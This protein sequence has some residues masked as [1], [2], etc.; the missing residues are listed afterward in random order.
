ML[1]AIGEPCG[2]EEEG[3]EEEGDARRK[4]MR[5]MKKAKQDEDE[6]E[7]DGDDDEE[8]DDEEGDDEAGDEE[9]GDE[10][11]G[12]EA[13]GD[14][15]SSSSDEVCEKIIEQPII[16]M[17]IP[18]PFCNENWNY[19]KSGS[20]WN[21]KCSESLSQSPIN[22]KTTEGCSVV[23]EKRVDFTFFDLNTCDLAFFY[24]DNMLKLKCGLDSEE[25]CEKVIFAKLI[26]LD[27]T[28]YA[29]REIRFHTPSEH[30]LD[31][32]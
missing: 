32:K 30:L 11:E 20:N 15:D 18:S 26:D 22:L 23:T 28:E 19:A 16:M 3:D 4:N 13:E 27:F 24:E 6:E 10:A 17:P 1:T 5:A 21:C 8:G 25:E 14:D 29:A 31:G 12:D 2:D 9:E 7:E